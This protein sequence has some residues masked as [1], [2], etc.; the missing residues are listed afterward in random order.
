[1]KNIYAKFSLRVI[2]VS[3][4]FLASGFAEAQ[5]TK[6]DHS[7]SWGFHDITSC[8]TNQYTTSFVVKSNNRATV[9]YYNNG[10]EIKVNGWSQGS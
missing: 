8:G 7:L 6:G 2:I 4:F 1:M 9:T 10:T 3:L 5:I